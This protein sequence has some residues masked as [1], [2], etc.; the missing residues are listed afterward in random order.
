L[1]KG[2]R[3]AETFPASRVYFNGSDEGSSVTLGR[4]LLL[5]E[6]VLCGEVIGSRL[7]PASR[8]LADGRVV[9]G[10]D[11]VVVVVC[12]WEGTGLLLIMISG[13]DVERNARGAGINEVSLVTGGLLLTGGR[14]DAFSLAG[15]RGGGSGKLLTSSWGP[16]SALYSMAAICG[17]SWNCADSANSW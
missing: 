7:K 10:D 8:V 11:D 6:S 15:L 1:G 4:L 9:D 5:V 14:E 2:I 17:A 16:F 3:Y 13:D 12:E